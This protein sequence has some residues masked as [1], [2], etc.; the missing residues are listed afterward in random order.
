MKI[1]RKIAQIKDENTQE[2][3]DIRIAYST[4]LN[5]AMMISF[6]KDEYGNARRIYEKYLVYSNALQLPFTQTNI[7]PCRENGN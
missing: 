4:C 1:A 5:R 6:L 3:L 2:A 7:V